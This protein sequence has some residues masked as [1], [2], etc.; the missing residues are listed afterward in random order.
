MVAGF[1]EIAERNEFF[2]C[3][4]RYAPNLQLLSI[5]RERTTPSLQ[6]SFRATKNRDT[7]TSH[8]I[9]RS[10]KLNRSP[11]SQR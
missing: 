6:N 2:G 9:L 4:A 5:P 7:L 1:V 11:Y 10:Y 8:L 3:G